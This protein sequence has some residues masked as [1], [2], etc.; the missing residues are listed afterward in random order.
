[1]KDKEDKFPC[2]MIHPSTGL[3]VKMDS[4]YGCNGSGEVVGTGQH[5]PPTYSMGTYKDTW[6][7]DNFKL[8][9]GVINGNER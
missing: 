9:T 1:M 7:I 5:N 4:R 2:L 8:F 6:S 3:L